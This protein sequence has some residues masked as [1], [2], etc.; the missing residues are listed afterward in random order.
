MHLSLKG[1]KLLVTGASDDF[2]NEFIYKTAYSYYDLNLGRTNVEIIERVAFEVSKEGWEFPT[3]QWL[4]AIELAAIRTGEP[5]DNPE[6]LGEINTQGGLLLNTHHLWGNQIECLNKLT[7]KKHGIAIM[8]TGAGKTTMISV[9]AKNLLDAGKKVIVMA[10]TNAVL[11]EIRGRFEEDFGVDC[12]YYFDPEKQIQ[13]LNPKGFFKSNAFWHRDAY[14]KDVDCI[15]MDEVENCMNERFLRAIE[16]ISRVEH[17]YGFSGTASRREGTELNFIKGGNHTDN[18]INLVSQLGG[19]SWYEKP[20]DI[21]L[22]IIRIKPDINFNLPPSNEYDLLDWEVAN[23]DNEEVLS[24]PKW[25]VDNAFNLIQIYFAGSSQLHNTVNN[26]FKSNYINNLFIPFTSRVAISKFAEISN[27][28]IGTITGSGFQYRINKGDPWITV[29][30]KEFKELM[31]SNTFD[32]VLASSAGFAGFD[33]S[34]NWDSALINSIG[35]NASQQVQS[36]GRVARSA[37]KKMNCYYMLGKYN[38]PVYNKQLKNAIRLMKNYYSEG[39][40]NEKVVI[41]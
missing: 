36:L 16:K 15:I 30:L 23:I 6:F 29:N 12:K 8:R 33:G 21:E 40:V 34:K 14:W 31:G 39:V 22:N 32:L 28:S 7:S 13:F 17:I 9:L 18:E 41:L 24:R 37:D 2:G 25:K 4:Y 26:L 3:L 1:K 10:P 5:I 27:R 19:T 20:V 35:N 11:H 38:P